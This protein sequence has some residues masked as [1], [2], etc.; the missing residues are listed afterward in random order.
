[1][2]GYYADTVGL[3][4]EKI[5]VYAKYQEKREREVEQNKFDFQVNL[6]GNPPCPLRR[7]GKLI[8]L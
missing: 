6:G 7:Q 5:W 2:K 3:D 8:P 4:E 1:V